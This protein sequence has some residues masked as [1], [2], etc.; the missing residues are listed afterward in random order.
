MA[1]ETEVEDIEENETEVSGE[2]GVG[3][4]LKAAR[5][6]KGMSLDDVAEVTRVPLRHLQVIDED[7]WGNLPART[8]AIGFARSYA[9]AVG[10]DQ[11]EI[12]ADVRHQMSGTEDHHPTPMASSFEPGDPTRVSSK[13]LAW[14]G[15]FAAILL[16]VGAF[17]FFKDYFNPVADPTSLLTLEEEE[18]AAQAEEKQQAQQ[19][20]GNKGASGGPVIFTALEDDIW[21]RFSDAD[22][23]RLYE[24]V[25]KKG[26]SYEVPQSARQP[27][28][29]TGRPDALSIT[30]GGKT[31]PKLAQEPQT[32][33][34]AQVSAQALLARGNSATAQ[35]GGAAGVGCNAAG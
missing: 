22:G 33:G 18:A 25:M 2:E 19:A 3:H 15:A 20:S 5:K 6:E 10:L 34:D 17:A 21:V 12:A 14:F 8:Y 28:L 26:E 31:V 27:E 9:K 7:E 11:N 13:G 16:A 1:E 24:K 30:I 4:R 29:N 35:P 23:N 32:L